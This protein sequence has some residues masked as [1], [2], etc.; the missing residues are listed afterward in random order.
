MCG[1]LSCGPHWEQGP[2]PRHVPRLGIEQAMLCLHPTLHPL[3]HTS[4]VYF[5]LL[6]QQ[7]MSFSTSYPGL[8]LS[9]IKWHF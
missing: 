6:K 7:K 2:Q 5:Y 3:S 8:E 9:Y 1:C 4:Q